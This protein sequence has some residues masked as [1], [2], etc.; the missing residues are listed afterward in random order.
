M[1]DINTEFRGMTWDDVV[2]SS[3]AKALANWSGAIPQVVLFEGPYGTGKNLHAYLLA[4][5]IG[6]VEITVRDSA[7]NTAASALSIIH[8]FSTPPL[9]PTLNQVCI[10]NE[11]HLFRK[12]AQRKFLDLLQAPP[13][14]TYLFLVSVEPGRIAPDI[15]NRMM[16]IVKTRLLSKPHAYELACVTCEKL[17]LDLGKKKKSLIADRSEGRPR[18]I[19]KTIQAIKSAGEDNDSFI[20]EML[21]VYSADENH[22]QFMLLYKLLTVGQSK[23]MKQVIQLIEATETDAVTIQH[24]MLNMIWKYADFKAL[25]LYEALIPRLEEG[26]EKHDLLVRCLRLLRQRYNES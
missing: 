10:I 2:G 14:R 24:K 13:P 8:Q 1:I 3:A 21:K 11:F 9:V 16:V 4:Q 7:D 12:D 26:R 23:T 19:I 17:N 6:E 20:D 18:T 22:E 15:L 5:D 25:R